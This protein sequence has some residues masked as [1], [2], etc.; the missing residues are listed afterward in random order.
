M[1]QKRDV[2]L[3]V[4]EQYPKAAMERRRIVS[5]MLYLD[6]RL[7]NRKAFGTRENETVAS[8]V[9]PYRITTTNAFGCQFF[10]SMERYGA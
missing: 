7:D 6:L 2:P 1:K 9:H 4:A 10:G 3:F 5:E 8:S